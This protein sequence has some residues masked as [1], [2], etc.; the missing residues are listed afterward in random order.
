MN[1]KLLLASLIVITTAVH[2]APLKIDKVILWGHK[3]HSHTHSY[4]H[5]GFYRAFKHLGCE[6]HWLNNADDVSNFDFSNSLFITEGQVDQKMPIR[7]DSFYIL[8]NCIDPRYKELRKTNRCITLQVYTHDCKE[9][10]LEY[11]DKFMCYSKKEKVIY[12]PWATDLLPHEIDEVKKTVPQVEKQSSIYFVGSIMGGRFGNQNIV[13]AFAQ[14]ARKNQLKFSHALK[15]SMED[16]IKLI[17]QS[18][19][20]P[21]LQGEWQCKQGYIPCRI[22]KNISYGQWGITNS[23][24]VYELF[25]RKIIYDADPAQ[26]F[27][28]AQ[29]HIKHADISELYELMDIVKSKH[30]YLNRIEQLLWFLAEIYNGEQKKQAQVVKA[31]PIEKYKRYLVGGTY[32]GQSW[33]DFKT[34]PK[35]RYYTFKRAFE[36]FETNNGKVI[37]ELGT[38][39]SFVHGGHPGCLKGDARYWTVDKPKNWDWGNGFFTRLVAECLAHTNPEIHVVDENR[40]HINMA[41][42]ITKEFA[43]VMHYHSLSPLDFLEKCTFKNGID[44]LYLNEGNLNPLEPT[45]IF[46]YHVADLIVERKLMAKNGIIIINDIKSQVTKK[47]GEKSDLSR[48]KYAIPYLVEN[49]FEIIEDEY[50]VILKK[51]S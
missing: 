45:A 38:T 2:A 10:E 37:V 22:F 36:H 14:E 3:L 13:N 12:L 51:V 1:K 17:Q 47:F 29:E 35:S 6:T 19:M 40:G 41:K 7:D 21:A 4:I 18:Y 20:A 8:H 43:H 44:L 24:T 27:H 23:E 31:S 11:L 30:T 15:R 49:G 28:K 48:G 46:D 32:E 9:R 25:D 16:N 5:W 26:L 34:L 50:Q 33:K 42:T 39:R